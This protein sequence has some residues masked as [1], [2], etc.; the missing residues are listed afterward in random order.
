MGAADFARGATCFFFDRANGKI[1]TA[2]AVAEVLADP[3]FKSPA[4]FALGDVDKIVQDQFTVV[5]SVDAN[6]EGVT[7]THATCVFGDDTDAS[8]CFGQLRVFGQ[9]KAIDHQYSDP[10]PILHA[11]EFG[12]VR[13]PRPQ[14]IT[15]R[16]DEFFLRFG[17]IVGEG[18]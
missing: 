11:G 14:W 2:G 17:P 7:E 3:L 12:I 6:N 8:R 4:A 10:V 18:K 1:G 5:P 16:E 13:V 15:A 9:R